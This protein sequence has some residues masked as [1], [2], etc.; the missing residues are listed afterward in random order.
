MAFPRFN[1]GAFYRMCRMVHAYLSAA[2]FVILMFFAASGFLLNHPTW[3]GAGRSADEPAVVDL[4][5]TQLEAAL[6]AE[7]PGRALAELVR[8]ATPGLAGAF[9]DAE[10]MESEAF[11]RF[12]GVKGTTDVFVDLDGAVAEVEV[13]RANATS[14]I[15]DL[16]RGKDA[17][18][19]WKTAIDIAAILI[20]AMSIAGL[21]LFF[22]LRFR[23]ATSMKIMGVTLG[24]FILL[25]VFLTP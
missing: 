24:A 4:N 2:A 21:I 12:V 1:K 13:S 23:L 20:L 11:L 16:H 17:G 6:S 9:K 7:E 10:V 8:K 18:T 3:L 25:F 14:I 19:F 15:H 5:R 22:S